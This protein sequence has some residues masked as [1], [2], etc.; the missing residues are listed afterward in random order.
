MIRTGH[1]FCLCYNIFKAVMYKRCSL[2]F[3]PGVVKLRSR[4]SV[5]IGN[6]LHISV[7]KCLCEA[8]RR[9]DAI[10]AAEWFYGFFHDSVVS[11]YKIF[12]AVRRR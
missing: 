8:L 2:F 12:V 1:F 4:L 6:T 7:K 5:V 9:L 11:V 10:D 3:V